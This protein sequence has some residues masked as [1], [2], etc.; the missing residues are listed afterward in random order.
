MAFAPAS[1]S[2]LTRWKYEAAKVWRLFK[3]C[4]A[5]AYSGA[6]YASAVA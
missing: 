2:E 6:E 1:T 5:T 4:S 3:P